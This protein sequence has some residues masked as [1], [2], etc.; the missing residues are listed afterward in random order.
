MSTA[1][2]VDVN[3]LVSAV[4]GGNDTFRSWPSPPPVRGNLAANVVGIL[5]D[6]REFSLFLSEY[7]LT[8]VVRVLGGIPPNGYGWSGERSGDYVV[9]LAEIAEASGGAVI[10]P[11][12]VVNDCPDHEDNRILECAG[13]SGSMLIVSDD[14]DLISM[15][16]WRGTPIVSSGDFVKRTD[17]MRR[18][19][20]R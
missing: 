3:V 9:V 19:S 8:N 5:D 10:V 4:V 7:I 17:A 6:A 18:R 14:L 12:I 11:S 2:T 15:S 13:T 20:R 16:S 1:V